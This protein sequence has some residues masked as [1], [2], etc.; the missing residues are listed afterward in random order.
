MVLI[1]LCED[2][3]ESDEITEVP[4]DHYIYFNNPFMI[5]STFSCDTT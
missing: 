1:M 4:V 3:E 2:M 5:L